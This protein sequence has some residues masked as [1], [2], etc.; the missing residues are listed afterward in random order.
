[1]SDWEPLPNGVVWKSPALFNLEVTRAELESH[2]GPPQ[3]R[4]LDSNGVGAY[5][6]WCL[7]FACGLEVALW[8]FTERNVPA[9]LE[10]HAN[11]LDRD[12]ILFH[13]A[14]PDVRVSLWVPDTSVIG[15]KSWLVARIDDNGTEFEVERTT[16][17]CE[18]TALVERLGRGKHKQTYLW[19]RLG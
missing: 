6:A 17:E 7:R 19:R 14:L 18:A 8:W 11:E 10:V 3:L 15:P 5:D 4:D 12:H 13:L 1:M 16:S 9:N 2:F